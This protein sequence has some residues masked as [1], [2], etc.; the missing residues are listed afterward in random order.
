LQIRLGAVQCC[1]HRHHSLS[2]LSLRGH[3]MNAATPQ[4]RNAATPQRRNAATPQR[5]N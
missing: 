1:P 5:R 4:R 2:Y 3:P